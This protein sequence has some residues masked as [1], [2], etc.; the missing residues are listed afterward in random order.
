MGA[1][2]SRIWWADIHALAEHSRACGGIG[3]V[4][5]LPGRK[6]GLRL[7]GDTIQV[8]PGLRGRFLGE[9]ENGVLVDIALAD[10]DRWLERYRAWAP[11]PERSGE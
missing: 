9:S 2:V 3:A 10:M 6:S 5:M 11:I 4:A 1:T 7:G 8:L